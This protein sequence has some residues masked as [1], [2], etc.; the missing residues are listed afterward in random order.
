MI[1]SAREIDLILRPRLRRRMMRLP[2][3]IQPPH[4]GQLLKLQ[5]RLFV[6]HRVEVTV[7]AVPRRELL[8]ALSLADARREGYEHLDAAYRAWV[9]SNGVPQPEQQVWVVAFVK[10]DATEHFAQDAPAYLRQ[11]A[12][13]GAV[14]SDFTTRPDLALKDEHGAVELSVLPGAGEQ[15]RVMALAAQTLPP[16]VLAETQ[17]TQLA[18]TVGSL[19]DSMVS[20]KARNRA[21]LI[22]KQVEQLRAELPITPVASPVRTARR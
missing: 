1:V 13:D 5:T 2:A 15:A 17:A 4:L 6:K 22:A 16:V 18:D 11:R 8:A 10:G 20:M 21:R 3:Q 19:K 9:E 14:R 7:V 12:R